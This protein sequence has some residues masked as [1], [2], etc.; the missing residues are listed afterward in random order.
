[1]IDLEIS[2]REAALVLSALGY[3]DEEILPYSV[4]RIELYGLIKYVQE[5]FGFEVCEGY[6]PATSE[7]FS[8]E[9][10]TLSLSQ[11][12]ADFIERALW[13]AISL[14][15]CEM[16]MDSEYAGGFSRDVQGLCS[17]DLRLRDILG[18]RCFEP[19]SEN[20]ET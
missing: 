11:D 20:E 19:S 17:I 3:F 16:E 12:A 14:G 10:R 4:S 6:V 18:P 13:C 7:Q 9:V 15:S 1:M 5:T 8:G 2:D